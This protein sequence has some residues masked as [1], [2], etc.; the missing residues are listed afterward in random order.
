M[1]DAIVARQQ[2]DDFQA[3]LF[4]MHAVH[5]L[6]DTSSIQR[7]LYETGPKAFDDV[8][9]MHSAERA[10]QD[11]RGRPLLLDHMQ[12]KW[13]VRPGDFG[14][15]QLI[16]PG[17]SG[18]QKVSILERAL[19]AQRS[20]APEGHGA[21]FQ[22]VT[23][24]N[25]RD[26]LGKLIL[27]QY[28]A[29]DLQGLFKGGTSSQT[30]KLRAAW[31]DHLGIDEDELRTL[32]STLAFNLRIRSGE[33]L[34]DHL[35]DKLARFG[36]VQSPPGHS[37]FLY[38][39]LIRK[40][41]SQG[42]KEFD[43]KSFRDLVR[44]EK[45]LAGPPEPGRHVIGVRSFMHA[46]DSLEARTTVNLNLVSMFEGR[47]LKE[48]ES[49][50]DTVLPRLKSFLLAEASKD[51]H[52]RLV[53]DAHISLAFAVGAVIDVKS[54]KAIEVEQ[55]TGGRRFWSASDTPIDPAWPALEMTTK[56][57]GNGDELAVVVGITHDIVDDVL[58][59]VAAELPEIGR[60]LVATP[61]GGPA[62]TAI[63]SGTHAAQAAEALAV[64][65]RK[66]GKH[67][68]V[69]LFVAAPNGFTFFLGQH[70]RAIG[71]SILYEF[72]FDGRRGGGYSPA[73]TVD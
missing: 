72:D 59:Y 45:L 46:I 58:R 22:L 61:E 3:R 14:Y 6:D 39:E 24:W 49:W 15:E 38:D 32:V 20:H 33:D 40:L 70:H 53:L 47:Y 71:R 63:K 18:A 31:A 43:R 4:W 30:G 12:C 66:I 69:H 73:L 27:Q 64:G 9:V 16:D 25:A 36:L 19:A 48:K 10:P 41:H 65:V 29:L 52:I 21:R 28:N 23:N 44:D 26:P 67:P 13:H 17:F 42:R 62:Q 35:N 1:A 5:L 55:R 7:V 51:D 8:V 50:D 68:T 2:G 11:H 37:G 54:G 60:L 34:R 56:D 57:L